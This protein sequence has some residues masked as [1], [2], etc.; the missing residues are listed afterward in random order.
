MTGIEGFLTPFLNI[1]LILL[2]AGGVFVGI[3][4]G[5]IPGL[6][7]TMAFSLLLSFTY[8]WD[9]LPA[10]ATMIGIFSGGVYGGSRAAILLNIPGAPAASPRGLTVIPWPSAARRG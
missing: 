8:G 7:V 3:Y 10:L 4:V 6:S 9:T 5:A 2:I 1:E